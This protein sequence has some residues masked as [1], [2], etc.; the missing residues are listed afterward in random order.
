MNFEI[1][2]I[3]KE[4]SDIIFWEIA[5]P[6]MAIII[7]WSLWGDIRK[8][9]LYMVKNQV[10]DR[11]EKRQNR[12]VQSA[13]KADR[14]RRRTLEKERVEKK[15]KEQEKGG[16]DGDGIEKSGNGLGLEHTDVKVQD[17]SEK[18]AKSS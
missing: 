4:H 10:L 16:K 2:P 6:V 18:T 17:F 8:L 3:V 15:E 9:F 7:P 14:I 5:L 11:V 1:M 13:K 12:K